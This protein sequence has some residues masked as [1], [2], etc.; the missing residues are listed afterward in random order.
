VRP[1]N[2]CGSRLPQAKLTSYLK[3]TKTKQTK[4]ENKR[5]EDMAEV[6]EHLPCKLNAL[7][8]IPNTTKKKKERKKKKKKSICLVLS[9]IR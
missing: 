7:V 6:A 1:E 9:T 5:P 8:S 2:D 4:T 3:K